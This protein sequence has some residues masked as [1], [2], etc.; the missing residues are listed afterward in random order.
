MQCQPVIAS[1]VPSWHR[2]VDDAPA[3]LHP[4]SPPSLLHRRTHGRPLRVGPTIAVR[5]PQPTRGPRVAHCSVR[6]YARHSWTR[7]GPAVVVPPTLPRPVN[8]AGFPVTE[9]LERRGLVQWYVR[10]AGHADAHY[11]RLT[12]EGTVSARCGLTL[13]PQPHLFNRGPAV[14]QPPI[15]AARCCPRCRCADTREQDADG[16][17]VAGLIDTLG[18]RRHGR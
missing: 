13:R 6:G 7:C 2:V 4:C 1:S 17:A 8:P 14:L 18:S 5:C 16:A 3:W 9:G 11:G 10:S 15:D 12:G